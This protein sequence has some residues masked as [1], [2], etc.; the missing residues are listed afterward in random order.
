MRVPI[1]I[2]LRSSKAEQSADNRQTAARYR[3]EGPF[4]LDGR[5]SQ[6]SRLKSGR[7]R[8]DSGSSDHFKSRHWC[9]SKH[10]CLPSRQRRSITGMTHHFLKLPKC[11]S[12]HT[13][14]RAEHDWVVRDRLR[15]GQPEGRMSRGGECVNA[16]VR[17]AAPR[18]IAHNHEVRSRCSTAAGAATPR[19]SAISVAL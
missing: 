1:F 16:E 5:V 19:G 14:L 15:K 11:K 8:C 4:T 10:A 18:A 13:A 6:C 3:A 9:N 12:L 2:C 7:S 17:G